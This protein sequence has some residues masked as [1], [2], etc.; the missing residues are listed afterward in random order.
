VYCRNI[1]IT[2]KIRHMVEVELIGYLTDNLKEN[3]FSAIV[4]LIVVY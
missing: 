3:Y 1:V 2:L 4:N